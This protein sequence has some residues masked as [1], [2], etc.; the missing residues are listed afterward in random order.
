MTRLPDYVRNRKLNDSA[1]QED[2]AN[3]IEAALAKDRANRAAEN[4][5]QGTGEVYSRI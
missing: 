4:S 1:L 3:D 5:N 2:N